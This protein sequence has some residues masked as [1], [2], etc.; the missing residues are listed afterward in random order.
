MLSTATGDP[1]FPFSCLDLKT[2]DCVIAAVS[3]GSDSTALL[4]LLKAYLDRAAPA[5]RIFCA[6]VDHGLRP[7]SAAEAAQVTA[8]CRRIG[9]AHAILRWKGDKPASGISAAAREARHQLLADFAEREGARLVL[10]GHTADDQAE[11]VLMRRERGGGPGLAGIA[12][13]TLFDGRIWFARPLLGLRRTDLRD[14]LRQHGVG[15]IEDPSN[16]SPL[17]ERARLRAGLKDQAGGDNRIA[18]ALAEAEAAAKSR[19]DLAGRAAAL[20]RAYATRPAAGLLRLDPGFASDIDP[21]AALHVLRILLATAGGTPH[22]P[23]EGAAERLLERMRRGPGRATLSRALVDIRD[24]GIYLR[25]EHRSLPEPAPMQRDMVWDG[26]YRIR[27]SEAE[28]DCVIGPVGQEQAGSAEDQTD[29]APASLLRAALAAEPALWR[30]QHFLG[31]LSGGRPVA[32]IA[33]LPAIGPWTR[34]LPSFDLKAARALA[35]LVG[36]PEFPPPPCSGH[37]GR[38]A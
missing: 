3:G 19:A 2:H 21:L 20:I 22:L 34:Y 13:A 38:N 25:R 16:E 23:E 14:Y 29:S 28:P 12:P 31:M 33:A 32:V 9:V 4:L 30:G 36:A 26:R 1:D 7:E 37:N 24:S 17:Y 35:D 15:W 11:T 27:L 18:G 8:L 6:T 5:T 10:T